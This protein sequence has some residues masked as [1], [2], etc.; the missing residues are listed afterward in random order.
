MNI[1]IVGQY[2]PQLGGISTYT[3]NVKKELERLGHNVYILTYPGNIQRDDNVFE[4]DT[5]NIPG[6]RG[7][8]FILSSYRILLNIVDK[9]DIEV[10]HANY[11]LPPALVAVLVKRKRDLRIVTSVHG[12]DM[13]ILADNFLLKPFI[14]Y[15]LKNSDEVYFVS[16]QL[17]EKSLLLDIDDIKEKSTITPN[18]VDVNKFD[19]NK[20][21]HNPLREKYGKPLV[22]FIGNLVKQKGLEYLLEA[23]SLAETDYTLLIYGD[24]TEYDNLKKII[25]DKKINDVYL[26]GKTYA[27]EK[28]IPQADVMVLPSVSEGASII[29]LEAMACKRAFISTDTGNIRDVI[30][31]YENGIIVAPKDAKGLSREIDR[32]INDEKLREKLGK[33]ARE[34]IKAKYSKIRIPY[35]E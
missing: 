30:T 18:T 21:C 23:K 10:I 15:T 11:I 13:N 2:P 34:T 9:Y 25:E 26:L 17:Y 3:A 16:R 6:I 22:V 4:A 7:L 19:E 31:D 24:G 14:R 1:C 27:P 20:S 33:N 12:S 35:I 32:L 29:A 8:S 28:I 5:I